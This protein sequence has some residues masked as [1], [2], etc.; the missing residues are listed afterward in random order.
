[1]INF[2]AGLHLAM[3]LNPTC[4]TSVPHLLHYNARHYIHTCSNYM[5]VAMVKLFH[6]LRNS[7]LNAD[8]GRSG[9]HYTVWLYTNALH[10]RSNR[11]IL[12]WL[13]IFA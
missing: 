3:A 7:Q 10:P 12:Q 11:Y 8:R 4:Y 1:M 6:V 13:I 5:Y 2:F 9:N